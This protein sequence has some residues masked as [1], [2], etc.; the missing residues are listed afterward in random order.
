MVCFHVCDCFVCLFNL[1]LKNLIF[2]HLCLFGNDFQCVSIVPLGQNGCLVQ[3]FV[4]KANFESLFIGANKS[5]YI[6]HHLGIRSV[7]LI[8]HSTKC[9]FVF[10][11]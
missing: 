10:F 3:C 4:S 7:N 5:V 11:T 9:Q 8:K 1:F 6:N 2:I